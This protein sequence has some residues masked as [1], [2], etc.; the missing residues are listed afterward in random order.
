MN[1]L[2]FIPAISALIYLF[3]FGVTI[4]NRPLTRNHRIFLV[5]LISAACWSI[6]DYLLRSPLFTDHKLILLRMVILFSLLWVIQ[7]YDFCRAFLGLPKDKA[8]YFG[9]VELGLTAVLCALG[10]I[11]SGVNVHLGEVNPVYSWWVILWCGPM[12]VF[13]ILGINVLARRLRSHN[14][15]EDRNKLGYLIC[16]VTLLALFGIPSIAPQLK[17]VSFG[18]IAGILCASV[19]AFAVVK[20]DLISISVFL[21]RVLGI[22]ALFLICVAA[23]EAVQIIGHFSAGLELNTV[24]ILTS[25]LGTLL[26][27]AILFWV[28]PPLMQKVEQLFDQQRYRYRQELF[29]FV[30]HKMRGVQNLQEL[31]EGLLSPLVKTLDCRQAFILLPEKKTDNFSIRFSEPAVNL[32]TSLEIRNDSPILNFLHNQYLTRK[33]LETSAELR[34]VWTSERK[35]IDNCGIEL[36][37]PLLNRGKMT[38]ILAIGKKCS[39]KYSVEAA[40]LVES[41]ANQVAV[42]LEKE[43]F[44]SELAKREK[45]LSIINRLTQVITSSLNTQDV[46]DR[47]ITGL[48][49]A[50]DIEFAAIGIMENDKLQISAE[51]RKPGFPWQIGDNVEL[52]GTG[53][54]WLIIDKKSQAFGDIGPEHKSPLIAKFSRLGI[55]SMVFLPLITSDE[56]IG[57]LTLASYKKDAYEHDHLQLLEQLASQIST[58]VVNAQLYQRAEQRARVDELTRLSNRRHFDE[59]I[60]KETQRHL[61]LGSTLTLILFDLDHFKSYNDLKGHIYGDKLLK[62][63]GAIINQN[64]RKYDMGFRYGGDEFALILPNTPI[65]QGMI[66]ADRLRTCIEEATRNDS[67]PV[68]ISLGLAGWPNDGITAQ[69]LITAADQAMYHAKRTGQNRVC[70]A[71]QLLKSATGPENRSLPLEKETL[72]TIYALAATIEARDH[73]TYGHSRKV[74]TLAVALAEALGFPAEKVA[75]ISHAA[76]LHDIGKI[77]IYDTILNKPGMLSRDERE[78]IKSHPAFSRAIVAH[79]PTLTPCLPA[80]YHHHERWDG[81]GYPCGLKGD[82]IP[83]EA[84]ILA[85]ADSFDAM[86]SARPYRDPLPEEQVIEELKKCAGTQFDPKLIEVFIPIAANS[87]EQDAPKAEPVEA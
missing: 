37:F 52:K 11:P 81:E 15:P 17:F 69:E 87:F 83:I 43:R 71:A 13:A 80:I 47:F 3:L 32:S 31:G 57:I 51:Y 84:R 86:T 38:G 65:E 28:R 82:A 41:I 19:L 1:I 44:Q 21:R 66:L 26:V 20:H 46:F 27:S 45:E 56:V 53:L 75:V 49:E 61:R 34:G 24:S 6:S 8:V 78:L 5:S 10:V 64:M 14:T 58:S 23:F 36:M 70:T 67:V 39:G 85:I 16:A 2:H 50:V 74:R 29:N 54:E 33:D 35:G 9:Y 63:V 22:T 59:T 4:S 25:I 79:I 72:N 42:C 68:T 73:Y 40:N 55:R 7:L 30:S 62:K 48:K 18:S 77:G 60:E 76:L 12:I